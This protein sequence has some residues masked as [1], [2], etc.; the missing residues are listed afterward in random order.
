MNLDCKGTKGVL[1]ARL[2]EAANKDPTTDVNDGASV[3]DHSLG[4]VG[5][6]NQLVPAVSQEKVIQPGTLRRVYCH[7]QDPL[8]SGVH[9]LH[10]LCYTAYFQELQCSTTPLML[11]LAETV[12]QVSH[13]KQFVLSNSWCAGDHCTGFPDSSTA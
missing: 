1:L 4:A 8:H 5:I 12:N 10:A 13:H 2:S 7:L 11:C 3:P 6:A 9:V